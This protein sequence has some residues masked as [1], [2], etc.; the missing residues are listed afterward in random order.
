M[1]TLKKDSP[2]GRIHAMGLQAIIDGDKQSIIG[3]VHPDM[4]EQKIKTL[5]LYYNDVSQDADRDIDFYRN[6]D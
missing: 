4:V 5:E 6:A 3:T 2:I 1:D